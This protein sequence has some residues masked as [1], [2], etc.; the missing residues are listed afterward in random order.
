MKAPSGDQAADVQRP[1]GPTV[2]VAAL[3]SN[4][5]RRHGSHSP[6]GPISTTMTQ[7]RSGDTTPSC[8]MPRSC[9]G[10]KCGGG[11]RGCLSRS[12]SPCGSRHELRE[13]HVM[14]IQPAQSRRVRQ[15]KP[16][17]AAKDGY[18]HRVPV[19]D[20]RYGVGD[21]RTVG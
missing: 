11:P 21:F 10:D 19:T 7:R 1:A 16:R 17:F 8:A 13:H 18:G 4:G 20:R 12:R 2:D 6:L 3:P 9:A 5:T 14:R 15:D